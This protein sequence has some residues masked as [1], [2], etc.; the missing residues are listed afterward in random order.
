MAGSDRVPGSEDE[1]K[2]VSEVEITEVLTAK[3]FPGQ[4]VLSETSEPESDKPW[5]W[6]VTKKRKRADDQPKERRPDVFHYD[7]ATRRNMSPRIVYPQDSKVLNRLKT[8]PWVREARAAAQGAKSRTYT[9]TVSEQSEDNELSFSR[10]FDASSMTPRVLPKDLMSLKDRKRFFMYAPTV[11]MKQAMAKHV[12]EIHGFFGPFH[13]I[14]DCMFHP[15]PPPCLEDGRAKGTI[16]YRYLWKDELGTHEINVNY[17]VIALLVNTGVTATQKEGWI[18][19][20]WHLSHLCGNWIC[21]NWRHHTIEDGPTNISR[22]YISFSTF[23]AT[24]TLTRRPLTGNGCFGSFKECVHQPR[25]MRDKKQKLV[26]PVHKSKLIRPALLGMT[27]TDVERD[28]DEEDIAE[29][30][31]DEE[32]VEEAGNEEDVAEEAD[33]E[34]DDDGESQTDNLSNQ[35]LDHEIEKAISV[36]SREI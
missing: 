16:N 22:K 26:L 21:C 8:R 34:E 23:S 9:T 3:A 30:A 29:E 31:G 1:S 20:A 11:T 13:P 36:S 28:D 10:P 18:E 35:G 4:T 24:G 15:N 32:D 14:G 27:E 5:P 33:D 25:C 2:S 7:G 12:G 19:E 17:G 6:V